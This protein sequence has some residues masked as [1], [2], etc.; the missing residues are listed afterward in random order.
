MFSMENKVVWV[1]GSSSGI[2]QAIALGFAEQGADVVVHAN[3]NAAGAEAVV[4]EI[5]RKG[6]NALLVKGNVANRAEVEQMTT[7]IEDRFGRLDVLVNNAG[8][9][10]KRCAVEEMDDALWERI[11]D[12]NL[13]SVFIVSQEA[14]KIMKKQRAGKIINMTSLAARNG[15]GP[16]AVAYATAKGGVSTFTRGL[17]KELAAYNIQ[18][19]AI[20]PGV[21]STPFHDR[22]STDEMRK[23]MVKL[24]PL[25]REGKPEEVVGAAL[26]L[27]SDY[28]SYVTGEV[29]EVNGGMLMD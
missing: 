16:G 12:T 19:N 20:G 1:T 22:H 23:N 3:T 5:K 21:I 6:R 10:V 2:G 29:I 17:A 8:T 7:A 14:L 28:A 11:I 4:R 24:I 18:V 13:T 26:Y 27:A 15:G 25:G 9:M